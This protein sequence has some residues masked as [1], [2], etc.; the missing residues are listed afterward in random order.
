M[1][2]LTR[3]QLGHYLRIT[4]QAVRKSRGNRETER[5]ARVRE[6]VEEVMRRLAEDDHG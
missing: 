4:P 2:G 6:L 1:L 5:A 3:T